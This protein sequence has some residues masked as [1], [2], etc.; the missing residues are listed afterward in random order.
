MVAIAR[1]GR[2]RKKICLSR[3]YHGVADSRRDDGV[4]LRPRPA[5]G[6]NRRRPPRR[7]PHQASSS[8]ARRW[9]L[10][11]RSLRMG[12]LLLLAAIG[13]DNGDEDKGGGDPLSGV[14]KEGWDE[15]VE[16]EDEDNEGGDGN[17]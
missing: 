8:N 1:A 12:S 16:E 2:R 11:V 14:N 4:G 5:F 15:N 9:P 10:A 3:G 7:R 13:D 6:R 17:Y